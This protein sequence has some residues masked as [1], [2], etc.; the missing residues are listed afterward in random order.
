M[1][2]LQVLEAKLPG[3]GKG[4]VG[5]VLAALIPDRHENC[6]NQ[7]G[8]QHRRTPDFPLIFV[9]VFAKPL[10]CREQER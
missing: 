1:R 5:A 6:P 8:V 2:A 9:Q 3:D 10:P 7:E 4:D